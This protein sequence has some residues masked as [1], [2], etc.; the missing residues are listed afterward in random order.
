M[1]FG[2]HSRKLGVSACGL[3]DGEKSGG[4]YVNSRTAGEQILFSQGVVLKPQK[5]QRKH[6]STPTPT[7]QN[8]RAATVL[9][10]FILWRRGLML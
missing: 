7:P 8:V 1:F 10:P 3:R 2:Y 4:G 9:C 6:Y 5:T